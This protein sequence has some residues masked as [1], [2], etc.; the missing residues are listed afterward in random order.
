MGS[1]AKRREQLAE[2]LAEGDAP[3]ETPIP[4]SHAALID[5]R[6][7]LIDA[8]KMELIPSD[9]AHARLIAVA[10]ANLIKASAAKPKT[11]K[12]AVAKAR[13]TVHKRRPSRTRKSR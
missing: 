3:H 13:G 10:Q 8:G 5:E 12:R 6:A 2:I 9:E 7:A 4:P 1:T 11:A